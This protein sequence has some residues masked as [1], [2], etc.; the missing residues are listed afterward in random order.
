M[1]ATKCSN[2]IGKT[3]IYYFMIARIVTCQLWTDSTWKFTSYI[4]SSWKFYAACVDFGSLETRLQCSYQTC[5]VPFAYA[6]I[7]RVKRKKISF[8]QCSDWHSLCN[9]ISLC[10]Q[11]IYF[12]YKSVWTANLP[13]KQNLFSSKRERF[14]NYWFQSIL[15]TLHF[16]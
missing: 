7:V 12:V 8:H 15:L 2:L 5:S 13:S 4:I 3:V 16:Q 9:A 14:I 11:C 1:D 6:C 10:T